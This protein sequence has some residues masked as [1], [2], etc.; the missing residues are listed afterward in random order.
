MKDNQSM[1]I[2]SKQLDNLYNEIKCNCT[3]AK[4]TLDCAVLPYEQGLSEPLRHCLKQQGIRAVFKSE[5]T[6]KSHLVR[7]KN[8]VDPAKQDGVVYRIPCE[9][10]KVYIGEIVWQHV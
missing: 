1:F 3:L 6:L 7:P 9:C 2:V 4:N 5:T 10:S 8:T